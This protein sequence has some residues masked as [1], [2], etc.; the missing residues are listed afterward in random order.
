M[1]KRPGSA[2]RKN[3]SETMENSVLDWISGL[4]MLHHDALQQFWG[5]SRIPDAF[6]IY[7]DNWS[8]T[9]HTEAGRLTALHALR[10]EQQIFSL[11]QLRQQRVDLS[12]TTIRSAEIPCA[13]EYVVR[14]ELHLR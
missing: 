5:H 4:E 3:G 7:D 14:V 11:K 9:A 12:A 6:R 8:I 2:E 10:S 13:H 1:P